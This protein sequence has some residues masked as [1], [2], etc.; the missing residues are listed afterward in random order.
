[1]ASLASIWERWR[2]DL[3][4][5]Y[6][7]QLRVVDKAGDVV[8]LR[9][10]AVQMALHE[11]VER[12]LAERGFARSL[13]LKARRMG[14]TTMNMARFF[15]H[16]HLR[17]HGAGA[18]LLTHKDSA[19]KEIVEIFSGFHGRHDPTLRRPLSLNN[20]KEVGFLHGGGIRG[21]T[22]STPDAG[23]GG[24]T[25]LYHGSEVAFWE[26]AEAHAR[27]S[28]QRLA[29][30]PGT[31][32]ML[33]STA[34]GAVGAFYE[35]WRQ[36]TV[37]ESRFVP[38]FFPWTMDPENA[39]PEDEARGFTPSHERP[40]ELIAPEA[41]YQEEHRVGDAQMLW[42][43]MKTIETG[44]SVAFAQ[45][46]PITP[47]EA[48]LTDSGGAL[49]PAHHVQAA[50]R[51]STF[52]DAYAMEFPLV[53]GLDPAPAAGVSALAW[54]RGPICYRIDRV[55]GLEAAELAHWAA[56]RFHSE[57]ASKIVVDTSEGAGQGVY[58]HLAADSRTA[59]RTLKAVFGSSARDKT[60]YANLRA[61]IWWA[62]A[63]W[64][65][66]GAAIV[67]E[68]PVAGSATLAEELLSVKVKPGRERVAQIEA[69]EEVIKRIGRSPDG[70][71]ALA[72]TFHG[73]EPA[74]HGRGSIRAQVP[75]QGLQP[76]RRPAFQRRL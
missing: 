54:R 76:R 20:Q 51:R 7:T 40:H 21:A 36:A 12:Q 11:S 28:F 43:R 32:M 66:D 22:A 16:C 68:V 29:D 56:E 6:A 60:R 15:A 53:L 9:L 72:C 49:I 14:V 58:A 30:K 27:G 75:H 34:D 70:A 69:K 50:L 42:R 17:P 38:H 3:P 55:R 41:E 23:R 63:T 52:I 65:A 19:T 35:R 2:R 44:G 8:P 64:L 24:G 39:V 61:E 1:M 73:G 33:E 25:T 57:S 67:R 26:H 59:G 45:E 62:M 47:D 10:N 71:D 37:G 74:V 46:Y 48:F 18:Y 4:A 5:Y 31:E 13:V